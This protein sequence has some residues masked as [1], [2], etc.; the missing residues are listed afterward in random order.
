MFSFAYS[1]A[2]STYSYHLK[3]S[4]PTKNQKT[5][6]HL[7]KRNVKHKKKNNLLHADFIW[8]VYK[9]TAHLNLHEAIFCCAMPDYI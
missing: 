6:K 7:S 9:G 4:N 5:N 2:F 1:I 3:I 8:P